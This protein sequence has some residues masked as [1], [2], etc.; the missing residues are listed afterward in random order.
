MKEAAPLRYNPP[1]TRWAECWRL[2]LC[3][4][5]SGVGWYDVVPQEWARDRWLFWVDV[6]IG[7]LSFIAVTQRRRW[8]FPVAV[9]LNIVPVVSGLSA[10]P[11]AL[12]IVSLATRRRIPQIMVVGVLGV[13]FSQVYTYIAPRSSP[14][15]PWLTFTFVLIATV[16]LSVFGMYVGSRRELLWSLRERAQEAEREQELRMDRA[17][18]TERERIAREM[19]DVLAHRISLIT[20]H[21]GA[22]SFRSDLPPAQVSETARLISSTA[23]E[24]LADLRDVLGSLRPG[25]EGNAPQPRLADVRTLVEEAR[26]SGMRV[27]LH[28]DL[29]EAHVPDLA[30]RT[31]YRLVQEGLTN[32]RKHAPG[33]WVTVT[34]SGSPGNGMRVHV[35]NEQATRPVHAPPG[36]G[37]GLVGMRE[38]VELAG[39]RLDVRRTTTSFTLQAWLPWSGQ[40]V[41]DGR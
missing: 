29:A 9:V 6:V 10:G 24:A 17:R 20:M 8:P 3:L 41:P 13:V 22:L 30:G 32:A 34:V 33:A 14:N 37:L 26:E 1:L 39:G 31:V 35:H 11:S 18:A 7:L 21:A 4:A 2:L 12:A 25:E 36:A 5:L 28:S 23:H 27:D 15:P 16:A 19:H 38:R 40:G